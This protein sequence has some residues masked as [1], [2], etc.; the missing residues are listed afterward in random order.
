MVLADW[1]FI[2]GVLVLLALGAVVGFSRGIAFITGGIVGIIISI[3]VCYCVGGLIMQLSF[4]QAMLE[5]IAS[6][7][8]ASD[9]FF[10]R[11]LTNI[12][13]E[14]IVY[15]IILFI[16]VQVL[17]KLLVK[18]LTKIGN[19]GFVLVKAADKIL[20]AALFL[21]VGFVIFLFVFQIIYWCYGADTEFAVGFVDKISGVF[22]LDYMYLNNPLASL[23]KYVREAF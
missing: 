23:V 10:C 18:L 21:I 17:R 1:I 12:H 3:F 5:K 7:W 15:Y 19:N 22:R 11:F 16:I 8:N 14:V 20:G 2:G 4:V 13:F 9:N 6:L